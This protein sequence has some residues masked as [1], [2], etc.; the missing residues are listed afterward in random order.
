MRSGIRTVLELIGFESRLAG[1]DLVVTG[2][3]R[4]DWQSCYGKV[5]QGIGAVCKEKN[6]PVIGL[7]GSLGKGAEDIFQYGVESLITSVDAPMP[8]EE[9]FARAEELYLSA[10]RRM[11][12]MLRTGMCL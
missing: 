4:T 6:I 2:E 12:R 5:M 8:M 10:A 3:G 11:F 1:V 9:A 7:S